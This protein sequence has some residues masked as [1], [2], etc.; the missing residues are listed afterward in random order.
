MRLQEDDCL[1]KEWDF[2]GWKSR[3]HWS[4]G[5]GIRLKDVRS[6]CPR[7][8]GY[9]LRQPAGSLGHGLSQW[10]S[11]D[12]VHYRVTNLQLRTSAGKTT[13]SVCTKQY[14]WIGSSTDNVR[15]DPGPA[16]A[17]ELVLVS[18]QQDYEGGPNPILGKII[19]V[20]YA[21]YHII[22]EPSSKVCCENLLR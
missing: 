15:S 17:P 18:V 10:D 4:D 3:G 13:P 12:D 20:M 6:N 22:S 16:G 11:T 7:T 21:P 2:R 14:S 19:S 8:R 5:V 1:G 9:R